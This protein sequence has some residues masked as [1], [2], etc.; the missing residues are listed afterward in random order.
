MSSTAVCFAGQ[1]RTFAHTA[2]HSRSALLEA[3]SPAA[4]AFIFVNLQDTGKGGTSLHTENELQSVITE[5]RPVAVARYTQR[6]YDDASAGW[7][8]A[9]CSWKKNGHKEGPNLWVVTRCFALVREHEA[10]RTPYTWVV[11]ARPDTTFAPKLADA[12][13]ALV[14]PGRGQGKA[15]WFART[16]ASDNFAVLTRA[17]ATDYS[18][19]YESLRG[20]CR[21]HQF[22]GPDVC[23]Q[24]RAAWGSYEHAA[25]CLIYRALV[26]SGVNVTFDSRV[27]AQITR[28]PSTVTS[29][30]RHHAR[31][32]R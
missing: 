7:N 27:K 32:R 14:V 21:Y 2:R 8:V 17:A 6:N 30:T 16:T 3:F 28:L 4:D 10:Q 5:L 24:Q 22:P 1:F 11:R 19:I 18:D 23:R 29:A 13:R 25:E 12:I 15:A 20:P 31:P 26:G 9:P